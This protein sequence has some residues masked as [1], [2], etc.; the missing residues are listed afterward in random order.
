MEGP[1]RAASAAPIMTSGITTALARLIAG[2]MGYQ[3]QRCEN[4]R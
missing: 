1:C 4:L 2:K 3:A